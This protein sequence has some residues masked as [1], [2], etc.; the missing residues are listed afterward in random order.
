[1]RETQIWLGVLPSVLEAF[2]KQ[3]PF[4]ALEVF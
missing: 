4:L 1:M 2:A 3:L